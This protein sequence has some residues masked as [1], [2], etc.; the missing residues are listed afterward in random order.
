MHQPTFRFAPSPNGH[1]H[2]G[3]AYSALLN[4]KM[5]RNHGGK[6]LLRIEDID[7]QRCTPELELQMLNDLE[8]IG[9]EWDEEPRRQS[10]HFEEYREA[11]KELDAQNLVYPSF[12]SRSEIKKL[13]RTRET[14]HGEWP[15]DPD[16]SPLYPGLERHLQEPERNRLMAESKDFA[17]RL[18]MEKT[19]QEIGTSITWT[20]ISQDGKSTSE[21]ERAPR[22][23]G[24]VVLARKDLPVS[25]HLCCTLDDELQNITH[26]VRGKDLFEASS[27]QGLI[28]KL[29]G[30]KSPCYH[31]HDLILDE[32]GKKLSKSLK[33]KS[34]LEM[35]ASGL[36]PSDIRRD[37]GLA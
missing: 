14:A 3:H 9:F 28:R 36:N 1:L 23:W 30:F 13:I 10:R 27:V 5:A 35:R 8:W 37:L 4:L 15:R 34:L 12:L 33:H 2:L 26:V 25:Y 16:G 22:L 31:H 7:T 20:E 6:C 11:L 19:T 17:L 21:I 29:L 32:E 24:D 18:D